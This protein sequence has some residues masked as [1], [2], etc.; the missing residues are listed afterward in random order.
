MWMYWSNE[1][2]L[3]T[4]KRR[5]FMNWL[6][7]GKRVLT[8]HTKKM[9]LQKRLLK[10]GRKQSRVVLRNF[11]KFTGKHLCLKTR[12]CYRCFPVNFAKFRRTHYLTEHLHWPLL[13][14][15]KKS[16]SW[17]EWKKNVRSQKWN[18]R[19][20]RW[21]RR[22][23]YKNSQRRCSIKKVFIKNYQYLQKNT[24]AGVSF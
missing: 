18:W 24:C 20:R 15:W 1:S 19:W 14:G 17:E 16:V 7:R 12:L 8:S 2:A 22:R 5:D 13:N 9:F 3:L 10:N 21:K 11:A 4:K 23:I 6:K